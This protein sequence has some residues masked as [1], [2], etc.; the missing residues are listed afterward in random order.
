MIDMLLDVSVSDSD[1]SGP[2]GLH[3]E[4]TLCPPQ[5]IDPNLVLLLR[6]LGG[7]EK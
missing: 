5:T 1:V 6:P 2:S 4:P 7:S 3:D